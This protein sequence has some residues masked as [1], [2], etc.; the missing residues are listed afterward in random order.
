MTGHGTRVGRG[1][2]AGSLLFALCISGQDLLSAQASP[3][4][5]ADTA[6]TVDA[7]PDHADAASPLL[8]PGHWAVRAA[9]RAEAMGLADGWLPAQGAV[10]RGAVLDAL[11]RAAAAAG[12]RPPRT[13]ALARGW[14]ARFREEFPEYGDDAEGD[15]L[16]LS[17]NGHAA[18]GYAD[19]RGRLSPAEGYLGTRQEPRPVADVSTPRADLGGAV[20]VGPHAAAYL[21]G[22][23]DEDGADLA[24]WEAVAQAG[25]L[26]LSLGKQPVAYGWGQGGSVVLSTT[27][28]PRVEAQTVR[29]VRLPGVLRVFGGVTAH[30]FAS[31]VG[32]GRH[33]D[34]PWL[35]GA[36]IAFQPHRRLT[37]AVNRASMFGGEEAV[38]AGRVLKMLV[39]VI[40][41]SAFEN[42]ILSFEGRWRLPTD[43][44]LPATVYLE[45]GADDGA[46][47]LDEVPA[48]VAGVLFPSLPGLPE[49]AAG[50]EGAHF[51]DVCCGHGPWYFNS[52]HPGNWAR[53]SRPLGHPLGGEGW[54]AAGY[55]R[56]DLLQSRLRLHLR[57]MLRDRSDRSLLELG[58]GNLFAPA[59]TGRGT[60]FVAEGAYRWSPHRELRAAVRREAGDGWSERTV[61]AALAVFF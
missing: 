19:E 38:T 11:E 9:Q 58:G 27:L 61:D 13:A 52:T 36:R 55:L 45:W 29:P 30:T 57:G 7:H 4:P 20:R 35:W 1:V 6:R 53:G 26:A 3:L 40:R 56:A 21:L 42:Q 10:P 51:P 5:A 25:P 32:G 12:E 34:E 16:L 17:I 31:R 60:G 47:A 54:E 14:L 28:L 23:V 15:A 8:P 44:V 33:P 59:R 24:R 18:A 49:V 43:A 2:R 37:F 41:S 39:G 46:G 50:V 48:R 22:R